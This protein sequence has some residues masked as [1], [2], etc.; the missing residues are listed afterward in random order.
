MRRSDQRLGMDSAFQEPEES[1]IYRYQHPLARLID[2]MAEEY[3]NPFLI[4]VILQVFG[5][6][7][8]S[9]IIHV[10]KLEEVLEIQQKE[11]YKINI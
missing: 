6:A 4:V 2:R 11:I 3:E 8:L 9:Y 1:H 5:E 7:M 10:R